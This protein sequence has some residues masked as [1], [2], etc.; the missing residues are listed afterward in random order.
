MIL[1][2][3][4]LEEYI[5]L[6]SVK[7]ILPEALKLPISEYNIILFGAWLTK[8]TF[9]FQDLIEEVCLCVNLFMVIELNTL[10]QRKIGASVLGIIKVI[11][12]HSTRAVLFKHSCACCRL[13]KANV[14]I[15]STVCCLVPP[16]FLP[17]QVIHLCE[18]SIVYIY[19]SINVEIV[20]YF[21]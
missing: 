15:L 4:A 3:Q 11:A 9:S 10:L 21:C 1:Q 2:S 20:S 18:Y 14:F 17:L 6:N 16:E 8:A 7:S 13:S 12:R 19:V 5:T